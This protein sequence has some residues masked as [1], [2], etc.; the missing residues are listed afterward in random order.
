M[1]YIPAWGGFCSYGVAREIIWNVENLGPASNP[2]YWT[3]YNGVLYLF[4]R[5]GMT[6]CAPLLLK[7]VG[8]VVYAVVLF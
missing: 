5:Y 2:D 7:L 1:R 4:R 8:T 3:I 6:N